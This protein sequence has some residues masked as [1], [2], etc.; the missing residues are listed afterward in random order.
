MVSLADIFRMFVDDSAPVAFRGYDGSLVS[1]QNAVAVIDVRSPVALRYVLTAPGEL[2]LARAYVAGTLDVRGDLYAALRGIAPH[3]RKVGPRELAQLLTGVRWPRGDAA[4]VPPE[5]APPRL[6]RGLVAHTRGRDA[7]AIAHH[8]DLSNRF[9]E[10]V[11]GPSMAY[12]CAVFT[13]ADAT[14]QD[15]QEE[16]FDLICRKLDLQAERRLLDVGAGWGGMVIHAAANYGVSALGVT[17]SRQQATWANRAIDGAGLGDRAEVR[18]LDYRDLADRDFDA[19][20]SI[21]AMEHFGSRRLGS[22]FAMMARLLR[23]EGRMLN[24]CI[25]RPSNREQHRT[26]PF[27]DRY[28]FPDGEL[29]APGTVIAAMH[30]HG[31]ELRHADNLRE[32]YAATLKHWGA[33]L[34]RRWSEAVATVGERRARAWRLYMA[35]ARVGF[36]LGR[37]QIHQMLGVRISSDGRSGMPLRPDWDTRT[38]TVTRLATNNPPNDMPPRAGAGPQES[39]QTNRRGST[40]R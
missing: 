2:G 34:E 3:I 18:L 14:L 36:E 13:D 1:R 31:F 28:V 21:G 23:P 10:L 38:Q 11:L 4:P 20:S 24:H 7:A 9:Y 25:T 16:K 26:G 22:H 35:A 33:N 29:Q 32:Q 39:R 5:E 30:D 15:A 6:R 27:I 37:V 19:I 12:S 17:L 40:R 8:Y